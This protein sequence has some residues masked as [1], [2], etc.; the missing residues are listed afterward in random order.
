M[1]EKKE[2]QGTSTTFPNTNNH[3]HHHHLPA[4]TTLAVRSKA[5]LPN[6]LFTTMLLTGETVEKRVVKRV[7][8][9]VG[10]VK[11]CSARTANIN[12]LPVLPELKATCNVP[13]ASGTGR[14]KKRV[15]LWGTTSVVCC[16]VPVD[17]MA[18][19]KMALAS[20]VKAPP[21]LPNTK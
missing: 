4:I 16:H 19:D 12:A 10:R 2:I 5:V 3:H 8:K 11:L 13:V 1:S 14:K 20:N 6:T 18:M 21:P 9:S 17:T 15:R 7:E